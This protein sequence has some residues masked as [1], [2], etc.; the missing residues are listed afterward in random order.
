MKAEPAA[1]LV[2]DQLHDRQVQG[3]Q[4]AQHVGRQGAG[5]IAAPGRG[6][7]AGAAQVE[8]VEV[9][10]CSEVGHHVPPGVPV[11]RE[12]VQQHRRPVRAGLGDVEAQPVALDL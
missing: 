9:V 8:G 1:P 10:I 2:P 3:V 7:L 6:G 4:H 12:A 5:V 11:L